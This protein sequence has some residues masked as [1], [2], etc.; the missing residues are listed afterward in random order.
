[1]ERGFGGTKQA[2]VVYPGWDM[3]PDEFWR[4]RTTEILGSFKQ[5]KQGENKTFRL[6]I[7]EYCED[8]RGWEEA[9]LFSPLHGLAYEYLGTMR[10]CPFI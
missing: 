10:S 8:P 7:G 5:L 9:G 1:M 4:F 6:L 3:S 2:R